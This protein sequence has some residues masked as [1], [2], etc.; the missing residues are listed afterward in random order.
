MKLLFKNQINSKIRTKY[1]MI[2]LGSECL[3][4][5]S[6]KLEQGGNISNGKSAYMLQNG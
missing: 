2:I 4:S 1:K 3:N 6:I 5:W